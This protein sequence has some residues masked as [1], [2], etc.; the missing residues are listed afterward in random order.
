M[1]RGVVKDH[2]LPNDYNFHFA[3][4]VGSRTWLSALKRF[5]M[6][7]HITKQNATLPVYTIFGFV[8]PFF[9]GYTAYH[10]LRT[11][12]VPNTLQPQVQLYRR[13]HYG[14]QHSY[15]ANPDNFFD[16]NGQCWTSDPRCGYDVGPK[17]PWEHLKEPEKNLLK[18]K[19][20]AAES[21]GMKANGFRGT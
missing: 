5:L 21:Q 10:Y 11:G 16:R 3:Q 19:R 14:Y 18:L 7:R 8:F 17:R 13:G 6:T 12:Y 15:N 20:N 4:P 1:L 2:R 9:V